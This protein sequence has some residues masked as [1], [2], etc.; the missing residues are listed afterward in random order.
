MNDVQEIDVDE[1]MAQIRANLPK[2]QHPLTMGASTP[3]PIA[4]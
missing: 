4:R 1:L 2:Q 3:S